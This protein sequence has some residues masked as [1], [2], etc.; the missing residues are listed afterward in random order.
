MSVKYNCEVPWLDF[1]C[2]HSVCEDML[3]CMQTRGQCLLCSLGR[4][5]PYIESC[6]FC[7]Q[8][9][10]CQ[11]ASLGIQLALGVLAPSP[12]CWDYRQATMPAPPPMLRCAGM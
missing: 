3:S 1:M 8:P 9:R 6:S 12:E 11:F 4:S 7:L 2:V 10:I 5:P